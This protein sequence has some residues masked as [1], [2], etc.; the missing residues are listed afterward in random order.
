[1]IPEAVAIAGATGTLGSALTRAC[2]ARGA[3]V[4]A[5]ATRRGWTA[6]D[7]SPAVVIDASR[8]AGLARTLEFCHRHDS[9]LLYCVSDPGE[10]GRALLRRAAERIPI[11]LVA[12]LS[13]LQW[14]QT[15][16]AATAARLT[17]ALGLPA[18]LTV[19]DRHPATKRDAPSAT[20]QRLAEALDRP[21]TVL[22][23]RFGARVCDHR[24][25]VTVSGETC[26]IVHSVRD[27]DLAADTALRLAHT[28]T[29][30][31]PGWYTADDLF[32]RLAG[33]TAEV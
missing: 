8:A 33:S 18:E 22:S 19:L 12:N 10:D 5:T 26:D 3:P 16:I 27:L 28:L 25:S 9:A 7:R 29:T 30:A 32:T 1:M 4:V 6:G 11:G 17:A 14:I 2:A 15:R 20:A 13:P 21:A 23:E 31:G 24:V